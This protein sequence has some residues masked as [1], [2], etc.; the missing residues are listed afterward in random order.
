MSTSTATGT[1]RKT[2]G[3]DR[4]DGTYLEIEA[5]LRTDD[6][7]LSPGFAVTVSGWERRGTH[8]G[9]TRARMGR[10]IDFGGA[11]HDLILEV[12]PHLEPLVRAHL[13]DPDGVPMHAL[14]NGWYEYSGHSIAYEREHYGEEYAAR[15]GTSHERAAECLHIPAA[16]LPEGLDQGGFADFVQLQVERWEAQAGAARQILSELVDGLG[17]EPR[18]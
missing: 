7:V 11:D 8:S 9:R 6:P 5:E 14:A 13:A 17:V 16:D 2:I 15:R 18:R 12:A 1:T 4:P 10:D 3:V